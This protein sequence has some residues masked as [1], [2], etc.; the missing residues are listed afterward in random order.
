MS[1]YIVMCSEITGEPVAITYID[2]DTDAL[3]YSYL[4]GSAP[5][6]D[7]PASSKRCCECTPLPEGVSEVSDSGVL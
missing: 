2:P 7:P 6:A 4:D 5:S 1:S 3:M